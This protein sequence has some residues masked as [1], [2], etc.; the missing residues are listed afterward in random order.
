VN[1]ADAVT[2]QFKALEHWH[3]KLISR[4]GQGCHAMGPSPKE[5]KQLYARYIFSRPILNRKG[6]EK[7]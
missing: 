5:F 3:R 4:S 6:L 1:G 2:M 7:T